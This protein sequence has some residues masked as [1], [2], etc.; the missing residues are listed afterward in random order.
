M[1]RFIF[2]LLEWKVGGNLDKVR[3]TVI[4]EEKMLRY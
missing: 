1:P 3:I 2:L 4:R